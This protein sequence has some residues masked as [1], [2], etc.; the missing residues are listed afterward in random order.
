MSYSQYQEDLIIAEIFANHNQHTGRLLDIGSWDPIE[1]SNSRLLIEQGW[2]A[3]LIEPSPTALRNL[4][5]AY[6]PRFVRKP[7]QEIHVLGAAVGVEAGLVKMA[8]TDDAVS[9]S[10]PKVAELWK[11]AGGYVGYGWFPA[12]TLGNVF[13]RFGGPYDFVNIDAEGLSVELL[14]ELLKT[15]AYPRVICCEHDGRI[16]EIMTAVSPFGYTAK[17]ANADSA[18][19][20]I[21][22]EHRRA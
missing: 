4:I 11:D 21:I 8:I 7:G 1:K 18:G 15:K 6:G 14:K 16:Q 13:D 5:A 12:M 20:N 22:L 9:T 17:V 2:S 3:V 10:D 19:T